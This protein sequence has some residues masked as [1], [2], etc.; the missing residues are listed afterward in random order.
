MGPLVVFFALVPL[1]GLVPLHWYASTGERAGLPKAFW[2]AFSGSVFW[3]LLSAYGTSL[4]PGWNWFFFPL[5]LLGAAFCALCVK[6][7][8]HDGPFAL[9]MLLAVLSFSLIYLL[10]ACMI[11]DSTWVKLYDPGNAVN[12]LSRFQGTFH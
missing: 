12:V 4:R 5:L 3:G 9:R 11:P 8:C 6:L 7:T 2:F 10:T 1:L